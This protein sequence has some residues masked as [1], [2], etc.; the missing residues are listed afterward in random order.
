MNLKDYFETAL[1]LGILATAD[2][3]GNVDIAIYSRPHIIDDETIAFIMSDQRSHRN[4]Q[5]NP[6]AAYLFIEDEKGYDGVRLYLEKSGE[7][8][9]SPLINELRRKKN[10][11]PEQ[12]DT[13]NRFLAYFRVQGIRP[14]TG[15]TEIG[16]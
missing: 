14:L 1:G 11:N 2:S 3:E 7:E 13:K 4:L 12:P 6:K 9:N 15:S 5:T 10:I 8:K 16:V